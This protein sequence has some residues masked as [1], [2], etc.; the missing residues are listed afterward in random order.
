MQSLNCRFGKKNGIKGFVDDM[1]INFQIL[2][3]CPFSK[4]SAPA[5]IHY[6]NQSQSFASKEKRNGPIAR[7][8]E[9]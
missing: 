1:R 9:N 4:T 3:F 8:E 6:L 2:Q 7:E 5:E